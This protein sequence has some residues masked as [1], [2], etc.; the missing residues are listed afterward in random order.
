MTEEP[1]PILS[2]DESTAL[3]FVNRSQLEPKDLEQLLQELP[4]IIEQANILDRKLIEDSIA[5]L[6]KRLVHM[7][8]RL[9]RLSQGVPT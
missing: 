7:R 4:P 6:E 2:L 3:I 1:K 9:A 5:S 8:D